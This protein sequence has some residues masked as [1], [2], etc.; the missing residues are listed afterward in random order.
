MDF[1]TIFLTGDFYSSCIGQ[2]RMKGDKLLFADEM[3]CEVFEFDTTGCFENKYVGKGAGPSEIGGVFYF[4]PMP[5]GYFFMG[6]SYD[7]Y[8]FGENWNGKIKNKVD[9]CVQKSQFQLRY[10]PQPE[11]RGIY[12]VGYFTK[13]IIAWDATHVVI[14]VN[15]SHPKMNAYFSHTDEFYSQCAVW[16]MLDVITGRLDTL[17]GRRPNV[18]LEK[19]NLPNLRFAHYD[20]VGE[21]LCTTFEADPKI[22]RYHLENG[23][24]A[25]F[26]YE[27]REMDTDYRMYENF[28]EAERNYF[29]DREEFGYYTGLKYI[30]QTG[31]LFR[32]YQKSKE[33]KMSG[34]QVYEGHTLIADLDVPKHFKLLGYAKPYYYAQGYIDEINETMQVFRF[35]LQESDA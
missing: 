15:V 3:F 19:R 14:P 27:G 18:Y 7:N 1:D 22:Y 11:D 30:T 4:S 13:E 26:G 23:F 5:N 10:N 2:M 12:E 31:M 28:E 24:I 9:F 32:T 8:Y 25:S 29:T 35:T 20:K 21:E 6:P 33:A 16:G 34:L 17:L